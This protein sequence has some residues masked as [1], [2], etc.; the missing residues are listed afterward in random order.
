MYLI[1]PT[2]VGTRIPERL[3]TDT[4]CN[5]FQRTCARIPARVSG[6]L[7]GSKLAVKGKNHDGWKRC[8]E[9][10]Q[11]YVCISFL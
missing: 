8:S 4:A 5:T 7:T 11:E 3:C 2:M 9:N 6:L 1:A 10:L